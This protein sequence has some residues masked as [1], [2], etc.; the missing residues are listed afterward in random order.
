[1]LEVFTTEPGLQ[2]YTGNFLDGTSLGTKGKA[3]RKRRVLPGDPALPGLAQPSRLALGR[4][5]AGPDLPA[6]DGLSAG[7]G[8]VVAP[9]HSAGGTAD[10]S[11]SPD[12]FATRDDL[13]CLVSSLQR[14][15]CMSPSEHCPGEPGP[16][17]SPTVVHVALAVPLHLQRGSTVG[18]TTIPGASSA[19]AESRRDPATPP[20]EL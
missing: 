2:F 3:Y 18:S 7:G 5:A 14:G 4:L 17:P 8:P 15:D 10:G 19:Q 6:D 13:N 1:M 12:R 16:L 9:G 11:G 20:R